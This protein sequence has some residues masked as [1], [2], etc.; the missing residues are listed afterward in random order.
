MNPGIEAPAFRTIFESEYGYV[1][2]SVVRLGIRQADVP[3]VVHDVFLL[4]HKKLPEFDPMRPLKPWL[5]GITY[6]V[7]LGVKR[8]L[9]Y[10]LERSEEDEIVKAHPSP[11]AS[12]EQNLSDRECRDA[13]GWA[14][15]LLDDDKRAVF[16]LHDLDG[17]AMPVVADS[18]EIP[19]NTAYSRLRLAREALRANLTRAGFAPG[20][21]GAAAI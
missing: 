7:A 10:R 21:Q 16:V 9:G 17:T 12:P 8:R 18:L 6:R 4:V 11:S 1:R 3:D 15:N 2:N 14:M 5:F 19:L 20:S 13:L